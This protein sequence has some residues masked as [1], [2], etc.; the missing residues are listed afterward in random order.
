MHFA[1]HCQQHHH[2]NRLSPSTPVPKLPRPCPVFARPL[3]RGS[4]R[5]QSLIHRLELTSQKII[6]T[7]Q[8]LP[9][10]TFNAISHWLPIVSLARH[11]QH[12]QDS[13]Q[14]NPVS[15]TNLIADPSND[16]TDRN[17]PHDPIHYHDDD[18]PTY[19]L[20]DDKDLPP[21]HN[22]PS[23]EP[24]NNTIVSFPPPPL[25]MDI[26]KVFTQNVHGLWC[27]LQN[28][29]GTVIANSGQ[30]MTKLEYLIH[31]MRPD[32]IGAWLVQ[33]TWLEDE[34]FDTNIGGYHMFRTISPV[35]STGR[36]HLIHGVA[37]ILSHWHFLA[38]KAAGS[39]RPYTMDHTGAF[40]GRFIGIPLK[41]EC[42]DHKGRKQKRNY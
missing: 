12:Q 29:D 11:N 28:Q 26:S 23:N 32:D 8:A 27:R 31:R 13:V 34:D 6:V 17:M 24:P 25:I 2:S 16:G 7:A 9:D 41:F 10:V 39:P 36:D 20:D 3:C 19:S 21:S 42:R 22:A 38:W 14:G 1:H 18:N 35:G 15:G 40:A 30:D 4:W 37:I 33:E 5:W